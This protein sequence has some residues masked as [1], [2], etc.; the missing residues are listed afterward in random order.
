MAVAMATSQ[1][2]ENVGNE[3][4]ISLK[5]LTSQPHLQYA[6]IINVIPGYQFNSLIDHQEY[7]VCGLHSLVLSFY[8]E[9]EED[10]R[11]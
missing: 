2:D 3:T 11:I 6:F 5:C 10:R 1:K 9:F 7:D 4:F 8:I